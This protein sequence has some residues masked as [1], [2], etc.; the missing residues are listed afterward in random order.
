MENKKPKLEELKVNSFVTSIDDKETNTVE[1]GGT[2][3]GTTAPWSSL[4]CTVTLISAA[5]K[6]GDEIG[7]GSPAQGVG[8]WVGKQYGSLMYGS[9]P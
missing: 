8:D 5:W 3:L 1:G 2:I 4:I 7:H 9:C 6:I